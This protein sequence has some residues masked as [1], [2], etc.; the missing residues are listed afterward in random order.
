MV[1]NVNIVLLKSIIIR[2][3]FET[4]MWPV[5]FLKNKTQESRF[6]KQ[7]LKLITCYFSYFTSMNSK[8]YTQYN[9]EFFA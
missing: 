8:Y 1:K 6:K 7:P 2:L 3:Q 4:L 9:E 5:N